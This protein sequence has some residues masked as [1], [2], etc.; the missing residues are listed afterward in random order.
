[1]EPPELPPMALT[2]AEGEPGDGHYDTA[3]QMRAYGLARAQAAI[4]VERERCAEV[5]QNPVSGE[6]DDITMAA[7]DRIVAAIRGQK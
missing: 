2:L 4:L 6:Q 1:M 3:D 5:A 7:K